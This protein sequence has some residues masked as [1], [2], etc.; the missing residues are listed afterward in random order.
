MVVS[1]GFDT[2]KNNP[3]SKFRHD[4][5]HFFVICGRMAKLIKP[6][7]FVMEA[8]YAAA[9]TG[10]NTLNALTGFNDY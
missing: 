7:M 6:A 1:C 5:E 4:L 8:G 9:K 3:I 10:V 2:H